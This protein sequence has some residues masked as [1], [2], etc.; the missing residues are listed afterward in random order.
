MATTFMSQVA[1]GNPSWQTAFSLRFCHEFPDTQKIRTNTHQS[2][3]DMPGGSL[4]RFDLTS[5]DLL[6]NKDAWMFEQST[7][8]EL[9]IFLF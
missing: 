7:I 6:G 9:I 8:Q 4:T 5:Y 1:Q 3:L 2:A